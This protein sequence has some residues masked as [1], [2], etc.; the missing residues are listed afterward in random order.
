MPPL[1][2]GLHSI[3]SKLTGRI[4]GGLGETGPKAG[5]QPGALDVVA[6]VGEGNLRVRVLIGEAGD[7][8]N[9]AVRQLD[10][11]IRIERRTESRTARASS[12]PARA[13]RFPG[14]VDAR[15]Q[16]TI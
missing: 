5:D 6:R 1:R 15:S 2:A 9:L 3:T 10:L 13:P 7:G 8:D 14:P 4:E 16:L 12:V 11:L